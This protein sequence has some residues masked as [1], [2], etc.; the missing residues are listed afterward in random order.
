MT[1][2]LPLLP[3]SYPQVVQ[4]VLLSNWVNASQ[5]VVGYR[6]IESGLPCQDTCLS[7]TDI[8]PIAILCDGAGSAKLSHMGSQ[9]LT[10]GLLRL[11]STLEPLLV[12]LLDAPLTPS[13]SEPVLLSNLLARHSK[14]IIKDLA[15]KHLQQAKEF[16]ST[17]LIT[18]IGQYRSFHLQIGDGFILTRDKNTHEWTVLTPPEKGEFANQ[19]C[20]VDTDL[21]LNQVETNWLNN[22][23]DA[24]MLLSDGSGE[25]L[26][27]LRNHMPAD[28]ACNCLLQ[29]LGDEKVANKN[30]HHFLSDPKI[31]SSSTGD[32]KSIALLGYQNNQCTNNPF[33]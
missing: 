15:N 1:H 29:W 30:L 12:S 6:H 22:Q 3:F 10:N 17:L 9:A 4:P 7:Q 32:D 18:I 24:V 2:Y 5:S 21:S 27:N 8:R 28:S 26:V 11:C 31:W 14:G 16:R 23:F 13:E 25:K 20:F 19:T 33:V